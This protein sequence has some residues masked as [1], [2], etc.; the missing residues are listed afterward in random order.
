MTAKSLALLLGDLGVTKSHNRPYTSNDNP[1]SE[2]QFK[3][4]KYHPSFPD[5]FGSLEDSRCFCGPFFI[6]YNSE[7]RHSSLALLTPADVHYGRADAILDQRSQALL[8]AL[9]AHPERFKGRRPTVGK[10]P[11]AVWINP[12]EE[13]P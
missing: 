12:P 7:H 9:E 6:W 13:S 4:L 5:H 3:T 10:L 1:F 2:A 11:E 8:A